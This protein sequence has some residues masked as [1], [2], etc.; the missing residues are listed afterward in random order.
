MLG[1]AARL[2]LP[3]LG[4]SLAE[5]CPQVLSVL[6]SSLSG[7]LNLFSNAIAAMLSSSTM[8]SR[9]QLELRYPGPVAIG[10]LGEGIAR[11]VAIHKNIKR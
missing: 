2:P 6:T 3:I 8:P 1:V 4:I 5:H 9:G 10:E 11:Q 7:S